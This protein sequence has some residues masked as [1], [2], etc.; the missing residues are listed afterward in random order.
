[1]R[2]FAVALLVLLAAYGVWLGTQV[3]VVAGG[4]DSSGYLNSAR[5]LT[6]GRGFTPLQVPAEFGGPGA[7]PPIQFTP[8]GFFPRGGPPGDLAPTYPSGLPLQFAAAAWLFGWSAGPLLVLLAAALGAIAL[9]YRLGRELGLTPGLAATGAALLAA[10]PVFVFTS[11]QPLS[12]TV[13]TTWVLAAAWSAL[14]ARS[15]GGWALAAGAAFAV[16]VLVRPTN[17]LLAPS[18]ALLI[19]PDWRRLLAFVAGGL[20]GAGW[21]AGYQHLLYGHALASGYGDIFAAFGWRYGAPTALHFG[22]WLARF[23]PPVLLGL[24]L[25]ALAHPGTRGRRVSALVLGA[26]TLIGCYLFYEVSHEVWWCLRFILPALPLLLLAGLL[27]VE[28]L[29][30]GPGRRW[31]RAFRPVAALVLVLWGLGAAGYWHRRLEPLQVRPQELAYAAGA[32]AARERFPADALVV[33]QAFSGNLLFHTGHPIL[34]WDQVS[35]EDFARYA[36]L[37]A[38]AGRPIRALL[39]E[40]ERAEAFR[41]C[42]GPWREV[43]RRGRVGLWELG[44]LTAPATGP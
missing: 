36:R 43:A 24:P 39:F 20:P 23:L 18:V 15:H 40:A 5:L 30:R 28:A 16:A 13:A 44:P 22:T 37:A 41:R 25:V 29:A 21:M 27:G 32:A 38:G 2:A 3:V 1:M 33:C 8:V 31:P 9:T 19:G 12:D 10:N 11:L 26:A 17:L 4:A 14:R 7:V 34:R 6:A 42:P 35:P